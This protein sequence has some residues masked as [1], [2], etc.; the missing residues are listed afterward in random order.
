MASSASAASTS[1][2]GLASGK[3]ARC[4]LLARLAA[5]FASRRSCC[6]RRRAFSTLA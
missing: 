2:T 1:S 3:L 4:A 6:S 5:F